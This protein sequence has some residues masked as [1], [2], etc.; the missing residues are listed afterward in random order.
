MYCPSA[1]YDTPTTIKLD[2]IRFNFIVVIVQ[3]TGTENL[4][5]K[6]TTVSDV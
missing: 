5:L 2:K 1:M 3:S 6:I 4:I